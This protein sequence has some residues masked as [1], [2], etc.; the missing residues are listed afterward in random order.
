MQKLPI[1]CW[2]QR[3]F[4]ILIYLFIS[5]CDKAVLLYPVKMYF[6]VCSGGRAMLEVTF[7]TNYLLDIN[8]SNQAFMLSNYFVFLAISVQLLLA[9]RLKKKVS[10]LVCR[11][12]TTRS[13]FGYSGP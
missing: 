3:H 1:L 11:C 13:K 8:A 12:K 9:L 5:L 7:K 10:K 2:I 6:A 4:F